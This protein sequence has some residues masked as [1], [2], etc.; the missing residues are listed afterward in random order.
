[1][2]VR[3]Q[4]DERRLCKRHVP[5]QVRSNSAY[6]SASIHRSVTHLGARSAI[7]LLGNP[8][9]I[10]L[11]T[12]D[13]YSSLL[14]WFSQRQLAR[15]A[16]KIKFLDGD[17]RRHLFPV[18]TGAHW[19]LVEADLE[20]N[21]I[22]VRD[23]LNACH[24]DGEALSAAMQVKNSSAK[25]A[26]VSFVPV[27][28]QS[29]MDCGIWTLANMLHLVSGQQVEPRDI[30]EFRVLVV[31]SIIAG[32]WRDPFEATEERAGQLPAHSLFLR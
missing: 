24:F 11:H 12:S 8:R 13:Q 18:N 31:A 14:A 29:G 28:Q 30:N 10:R 6:Q 2:C 5:H 27:A 23:S 9:H 16:R 19:I 32:V 17:V 21:W 26:E 25:A 3:P 4:D 22:L 1:M 15:Q 7:K 20:S